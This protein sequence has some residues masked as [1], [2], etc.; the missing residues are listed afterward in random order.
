M[1]VQG[2]MVLSTVVNHDASK[3]RAGLAVLLPGFLDSKDYL[4]LATLARVLETKGYFVV[5]FDPAGTWESGGDIKNYT[6]TQYLKDIKRVIDRVKSWSGMAFDKTTVIGHSFGAQVSISYGCRNDVSG[7]VAIMAPYSPWRNMSREEWEKTGFRTSERKNPPPDNGYRTYK[8]P[9]S[10][11]V[12]RS[13]YDT[14]NEVKSLNVPLILIVGSEDN[15]VPP[16]DVMKI[17]KAANQ[18]KEIVILDGVGHDYKADPAQ[19]GVVN[20]T[21]VS[22]MKKHGL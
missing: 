9:L 7:V 3:K 18:P 16:E 6:M 15:T 22:L 10:F 11:A 19:T 21:V 2:D 14:L 12:D 13:R 4:D 17:Y 20:R 8:V 1:E 5:R